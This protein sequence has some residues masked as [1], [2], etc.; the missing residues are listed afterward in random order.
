MELFAPKVAADW[1]GHYNDDMTRDQI[2]E[3]KR[4]ELLQKNS[5]LILSNQV[6]SC[7]ANYDGL[8]C[9]SPA[10]V[11]RLAISS[12]L[13][14]IHG[15]K[16]DTAQN[17][18][19]WCNSN[20]TWGLTNYSSCLEQH[21]ENVIQH[22]SEIVSTIY[23]VGY[24]SSLIALC[25]AVCILVYFKEL[26]C[27]RNKIHT[28]LMCTY[29]LT[30]FTWIF[31]LTLQIFAEVNTSSCVFLIVILQ[32]FQL[33]NFF[34]M[35]I[36]GLYLYM[37]V[38]RALSSEN[39]KFSVYLIIG[40]GIPIVVIVFWTI[41]KLLLVETELVKE[42]SHTPWQICSWYHQHLYDWIFKVPI[43][44]V[45][46]CNIVFLAIIICVLIT[47]LRSAQGVDHQYRKATKALLVL[48]PLF[49]V[50]YIITFAGPTQGVY[51]S[52]HEILR[53]TLLSTQ[54][55]I[56]ALFYC[57][58][59]NEVKNKLKHHFEVWKTARSF[60][61]SKRYK[62]NRHSK[63]WSPGSRTESI[64]LFKRPTSND[65]TASEITTTTQY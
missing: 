24:G 12:C 50:T 17:V 35:F 13:S 1:D 37:L 54:G 61:E 55:F 42:V 60:R 3:L 6:E 52:I 32:Y 25:V 39:I 18:S 8:I 57:F 7:E 28:N 4:C 20:G 26:R 62:Y 44:I 34:W 5:E 36:E 14:E 40:W 51:K 23:F 48:I 30:D 56:I 19:R 64:R 27:L 49:G 10:K 63:D 15:I 9:W 16:Y 33:T 59:N 38:V 41:L 22:E 2:N 31:S 46:V 47:K 65:S 43:I 29:I 45:L 53:A 58:L 21:V 11:D